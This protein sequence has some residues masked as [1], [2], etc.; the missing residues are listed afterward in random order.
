M[1]PSGENKVYSFNKHLW[2][3]CDILNTFLGPENSSEQNQV[4]VITGFTF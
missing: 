2:S 4:P 1:Y 3:S